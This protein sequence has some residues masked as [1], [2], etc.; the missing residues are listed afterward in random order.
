MRVVVVTPAVP[1]PFGETAARGLYVLVSGLLARGVE[2]I[3]LVAGTE[4]PARLREA[5]EWLQRT[6]GAANLQLDVFP[7][8]LRPALLRK[9]R[10]LRRPFS[11]TLYARGLTAALARHAA[12]GYDVLHLEQL[13]SGWVGAARPRALLNV[14]QF[15]IV[16]WEH[17]RLDSW[18]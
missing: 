5:Q 12:T 7:L 10:S 4:S 16:D 13:W 3:C 15:E 11:E 6:D 8:A 14:Y 2:V 18:G 17:R 1:H 9:W